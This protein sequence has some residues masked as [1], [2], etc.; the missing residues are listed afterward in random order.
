MF[1][2]HYSS[3]FVA[4]A[5]HPRV[6][7]WCL[8]A[9]A[10]FVDIVWATFVLSGVEHARMNEGLPSNPL[11]L[12]HMPYTHSGLGALF[13]S[14][15]AFVS[16]RRFLALDNRSAFVIGATVASHWVLDWMV[17][18]PDLSIAFET[19]KYGLGLWDYPMAAYLL[20]MLFIAA[21]AWVC[22]RA[23][24][25]TGRSRRPWL[26]LAGGL[27]I[28]QTAT[29]FGPLPTSVTSMVGSVLPLYL[30]IPWIGAWV[31]RSSAR[32]R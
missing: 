23:C 1:A 11:E 18:R 21:S 7:I 26:L 28:L 17:H 9:A 8:L 25:I 2:G 31:E 32:S 13:W 22:M 14:F 19:R 10:Q 5:T 3:A 16:A 29:S 24:G 30:A 27:M 12:Y 15:V 4:K 6:P 20:E